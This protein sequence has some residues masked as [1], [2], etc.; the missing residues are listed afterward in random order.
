MFSPSDFRELFQPKYCERRIWLAA[1]RPDLA[2]IDIEFSELVQSKGLAIE[3]AHVQTVGPVETPEYPVGD[4]PSGFEETC[5]LI[6]SKTPLI[7]QGVLISKDG[8]F[9]VIPDLLILEEKTGHYKIRDVKLATK[10]DNHPEIELGLGLCK[11]VAEEVLGYAP[12][13]EVVTGD[14]ELNSPFD[15]PDKNVVL[16]CIKRIVDLENQRDEPAEPAG[17]SKCEPCPYFEHCWGSAWES[18]DVCTISRIEQGM[19]RALWANGL[20]GW[21]DIL[22]LGAGKLA[23][24]TFQRGSQ[25]QRIGPTRAEKIIRQARCLI[26]GTFEKKSALALPHGYS[27]GD[28]PIVVFDIENNIFD[29]L[30]LQTDVYLWGLMLVASDEVQNQE[31]ILSPPSEE[32]DAGGWRQFLMTMSKIFKSYGDIPVVHYGSHEKTWVSNY[33]SR[34]GDI[35][36][37]GQRILNNLW[38]MYSAI[39]ASVVLPVPSYS[40]KHVEAYVG[41]KRS[42]EEYGGSW[43]IVRY[44]QYLEAT[45]EEEAESILNKIRAYNREDL[46]ATYSV[47]RWLEEHCC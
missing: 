19:S 29:E 44:N 17:W 8:Q 37:V 5:R 22:G 21:E 39:T 14:G 47:Y 13:I 45:D 36:R 11:L 10:L 41:F 24:I 34:Y 46:L 43:S 33:I 26:K 20:R 23:D 12:T 40:L 6:E 9:T 2:V 18:H 7:Y 38:N 1:N 42:Q 25:T 4:I 16:G 32:G 31:L 15:V 3:D 27:K 28:R 30:G 35:R